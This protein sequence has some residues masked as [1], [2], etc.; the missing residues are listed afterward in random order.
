[1]LAWLNKNLRPNTRRWKSRHAADVAGEM[2]CESLERRELLA[3][4]GIGATASS[5]YLR[6][7]QPVS[8][9]VE[10]QPTGNGSAD[11]VGLN[12]RVHYDST[13]VDFVSVQDVYAPGLSAQQDTT[14]ASDRDDGTAATDRVNKT[15]WYDING[16]W[17]SVAVGTDMITLNFTTRAGFGSTV[18]NVDA[19]TVAD[20]PLPRQQITLTEDVRPILTGPAAQ[21]QTARPELTW[22]PVTGADS[23][24]VWITNLSTS[25]NPYLRTTVSTNSLTP[26]QD[27]PIGRFRYWVDAVF[28]DDSRTGWSE[29]RT[30]EVKTKAVITSPVGNVSTSTPTIDWDPI[31]GA[32]RYDLWIN[33]V[34]TGETEVVRNQSILTDEYTLPTDLPLG[35]YLAWVQGINAVDVRGTWSDAVRFDV[36]TTPTL[37]APRTPTFDDTPT[38]S[39]TSVPGAD[40]Y[41]L[42]VRNISTGQDQVIRESNLLTTS[43]TPT[44]ALAQATYLW[45]VQAID[46]AGPVGLWG[47]GRFSVGGVP[48]SLAPGGSTSDRTPRF[49]WSSVDGAQSYDLWV[50]KIGGP[51][52]VIRQPS[53]L[54]NE[55]TPTV[56][57]QPGTYRFWVRA[58]STTGT[59]SYW[60][61]VKNFAVT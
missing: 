14:E 32:A 50:D 51:P 20:D 3:A 39:W 7:S 38:F 19:T 4:A 41:D 42:W 26:A 22:T 10:W 53:L 33:N 25:Q 59:W 52:Q 56:D 29:Q 36:A 48:D 21:V 61:E 37:L 47:G 31:E 57:L 11:S 40:R 34:S 43:Y 6:E 54:T 44:T 2:V 12:L 35:T 18:I 45:W 9:Q 28:A 49:S 5:T 27:L 1:M 13:A 30:F 8:V 16:S 58:L 24:D 23:Y 17:P 60:S 15:L 55:F 46:D